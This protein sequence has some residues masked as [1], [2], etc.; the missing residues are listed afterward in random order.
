ILQSNLTVE[1]PL[2]ESRRGNPRLMFIGFT[3]AGRCLEIGVEFLSEE[4]WLVFHANDITKQYA[5][6]LSNT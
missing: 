3:T 2:P 4:S 1:F 5:K 6:L